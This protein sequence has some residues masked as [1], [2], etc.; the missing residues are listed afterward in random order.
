M[1]NGVLVCAGVSAKKN[2]GDYIQSLAS[3]LFFESIDSYIEREKLKEYSS[4]EPTKLIIHGWFMHNPEQWPPSS[5]I[6]PLI[7]SLHIV[8]QM[9][10][11]ML[12]AQGIAYFKKHQ[13]IGCRDYGTVQLLENHS[14]EAYYS[15]CL[16][17]D[18]GLKYMAPKRGDQLIF[19]DP[20]FEHI[21]NSDG[22][23][24]FTIIGKALASWIK[25]SRSVAKLSP[26]FNFDS[27]TSL[28]KN[29]AGW[30]S[31]SLAAAAFIRTYSSLFAIEELVQATYI[32]H[33]IQQRDFDEQS[34]FAYAEELIRRYAAARLVVTSRIHCAL[35]CLGVETPVLFVSS[36]NLETSKKAIRSLGRFD[37][38]T[39][40]MRTAHYDSFA[41][42]T[43]DKE[44]RKASQK[45]WS[46][47][48][49]VGFNKR[50]FE[51]YRDALI[52]QC[53]KFAEN[54]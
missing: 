47:S 28:K 32:C 27:N 37:G 31:R 25:Y 22:K 26:R 21:K 17:L 53:R 3:Q 48:A 46:A 40:L 24:S 12:Q 42:T 34:K 43:D 51:K 23:F 29:F 7:T 41:L 2:I 15:S 8:P 33:T 9:A 5:D 44:V 6:K 45:G 14:I 16:T 1:K 49:L 50:D 30:M 19:V 20:Y 4:Q 13:P 39:N 35:P 54:D 38:I 52:E 36:Q 11:G 10:E 18:L